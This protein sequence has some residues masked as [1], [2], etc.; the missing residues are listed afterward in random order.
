MAEEAVSLNH[1]IAGSRGNSKESAYARIRRV[2]PNRAETV[3]QLQHKI[4]TRKCLHYHIVRAYELVVV[5][6]LTTKF[7]TYSSPRQPLGPLFALHT[8]QAGL[9]RTLHSQLQECA[10]FRSVVCVFLYA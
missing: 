4:R 9:F 2:Y 1:L 6:F 7:G 10:P 3:I 5:V 8:R